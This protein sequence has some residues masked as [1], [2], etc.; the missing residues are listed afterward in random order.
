[1]PYE[2]PQQLEYKERIIFGLT[3]KQLAYLFAF[4]P[5]VLF[6]FFKIPIHLYV[7]ISICFVFSSLAVGFM[8]LNLDHHIMTW[9]GWLMNREIDD[10]NI[11]EFVPI[12]EIRDDL[13]ITNKDKKIAVLKITP[14]NFSIKP[15]NAKEAIT[16]T[17]QKFLNSIDFPIQIIMNTEAL[18]LKE[19]FATME[20]K[21]GK[22]DR[23]SNL[24]EKY[25]EFLSKITSDKDVTN[26]NF[27]LVIPEKSDIGIQVKICQ[28]KL[29]AIGLKSQR[30]NT[31]ELSKLSAHCI[32]ITEKEVKEREIKI[33]NELDFMKIN[34]SLVRV[35]FAHGY[36]RNVE[37][38]FLDKIVSSLGDF[39][40]SLHIEPYDIE[41]MMINLNKELQKQR[42]DLF[43]AKTKGVL[44]PSLEIQ[45]EDTKS[46][47]RN[48]QKGKEKLFHVSLYVVC[49]A[50]SKQ[51]LDLLTRKVEADLNSLMII[52][53]L[54]LFKMAQGFQSCL[55]LAINSLKTNRNIPTEALS[56]FFPFTSSFLQADKT[57]IWFGQNKNNIPII[58]DIF[59]LSNPNG[60]CLASSG[61]GKSYMAKLFIAR[62][63]LNGTK[64]LV[65]DPQSE[66]AS[67]VKQFGGQ[68]VDLSRESETIINPLD[69][70]GHP[71]YEKRLALMDL[72]PVMLGDLSDPQKSFM[73]KAITA[74][75]KE[76]GIGEEPDTWDNKPP[77]LGDVLRKLN[78]M[79][80]KA[81][82]LEKTTIRSLVNRLSM[83][84]DGVFSFLNK[85]TKINFDNQFVCFD[86]GNMPKQVKP[87]MMFLVLDYIY[88]KMKETL[89]R[90][91][92]VVD[93]AWSL[94]SRTEEAS[95]I[96]EIVK[97]CRKF[98][99]ALFLINQEVEGMLD[100]KAGKSVLAN[101]SY[102]LLMRQ[103]PAV[104]DS[105]T[106]TFS[107]STA[108]RIAL[109]TANVGEGILLMD[110]D[111]SEIKIM[112]SGEEHDLITTNPDELK[113]QKDT[114]KQSNE[115]DSNKKKEVFVKIDVDKGFYKKRD[116]KKEDIKLLLNS[117]YNDVEYKNISDEKLDYLIK[118]RTNEAKN[119][120]MLVYD[121]ADY[122]STFTGKVNTY[123]TIKPDVVF[124]VD[125]M[126]YAVEV[127]TGKVLKASKKSLQDKV[128]NLNKQF[129][130]NWFFVVTD[131]NF[132]K[133]YRKFGETY[134]KTTIAKR[135][136]EIV[137]GGEN[138]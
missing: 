34:D 123:Q 110:D 8:F 97:T 100:S 65:I 68:R 112:A 137:E 30:L 67:L 114:E 37:L 94:L 85:E 109:L 130:K 9:T 54:P 60:L 45:Y 95:Y 59:K 44:N 107:L 21:I 29:S 78:N 2:I 22:S 98:N 3:F 39:N 31:K 47:L 80:K 14:I 99:L 17:F 53:K 35:I 128:N 16:A 88:M 42:A 84:V 92:L 56:A 13:I 133:A 33:L 69:L 104:I 102:T 75:Y 108:E 131:R 50:K 74:A 63:L 71:Y 86:I 120:F 20:E 73:D 48:L 4:A 93:E 57:G 1:M 55:P 64:V 91:L 61:S 43:A 51:E 89:D 105:I 111:H 62:H 87:T 24:F 72:M 46:V 52:P 76:R 79:E 70:M 7:R 10:K 134:N 127:E 118:P 106:K 41:T 115:I 81:T 27:Y 96:F 6:V 40:L 122:I 49:R 103:K 23:F 19:Y 11:D 83:Y 15:Q 132:A 119:H 117:G 101:S 18:D 82:S 38:G 126:K 58:K 138:A 129:G 28:E 5:V 135:L 26:R 32:G 90:K 77:I 124:E 125:G 12:K 136:S 36:P 25:K 116:L 113:V 66:Y 121:I